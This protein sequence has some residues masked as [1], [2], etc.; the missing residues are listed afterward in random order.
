MFSCN[1][2]ISAR[3]C[4]LG[5]LLWSVAAA[6]S[7]H[8]YARSLVDIDD[9]C[10]ITN[11]MERDYAIEGMGIAQKASATR[12][13]HA[14]QRFDKEF[15]DVEKAKLAPAIHA[16][17]KGLEKGWQTISAILKQAPRK[18]AIRKLDTAVRD[19]SSHCEKVAADIQQKTDLS[20]S[21]DALLLSRYNVD[22]QRLAAMYMM[23]AWGVDDAHYKDEAT[24]LLDKSGKVI[25]QLTHSKQLSTASMQR[26]HH[27]QSQFKLFEFMAV[28]PTKRYVPAL[29]NTKADTI[30]REINEVLDKELAVLGIAGTHNPHEVKVC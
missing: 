19:F 18:E 13:Q 30:V 9:L 8:P 27:I 15:S 28:R 14:E 1:F 23:R 5:L 17:V 10:V 24:T 20:G 29:M 26:L 4:G 12:L 21:E 16:E 6:A 25:R 11:Q 2:F 3:W 22:T 7:S